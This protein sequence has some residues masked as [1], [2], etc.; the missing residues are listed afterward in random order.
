MATV[1]ERLTAAYAVNPE[2]HCWDWVA[3]KDR[4]GYG[5]IKANRKLWRA[6][7]LS[8]EL[9]VGP[10]PSGLQLDHLCR[11]RG[12]VNPAHLDPV[13]SRENTRRAPHVTGPLCKRGLHE[14]TEANTYR[15]PAGVPACRACH[16]AAVQAY[17]HRQRRTT[18]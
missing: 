9:H 16:A 18:P 11:N 7:R 10:I 8:Y 17:R 15:S 3:R 12:C 4:D 6:H 2:T 13:S 1:L 5:A 14:R